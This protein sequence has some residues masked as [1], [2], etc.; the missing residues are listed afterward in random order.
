[1]GSHRNVSIAG[2]A[3]GFFAIRTFKVS[4]PNSNNCCITSL[5]ERGEGGG[6]WK[7]ALGT[8]S[9]L[10]L[11]SH[12]YTHVDWRCNRLSHEFHIFGNRLGYCSHV[13]KWG[14][15][16]VL[17]LKSFQVTFSPSHSISETY[18]DLRVTPVAGSNLLS[19]TVF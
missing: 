4:S 1:M 15:G 7:S 12:R 18:C 10:S 8:Q 17:F 11:A 5:W 19:E 2:Q 13:V 6:V 16:Y 3:N 14:N 9:R